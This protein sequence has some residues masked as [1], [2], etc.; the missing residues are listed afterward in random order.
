MTLVRAFGYVLLG[1]GA[2]P[3]FYLL[4]LGLIRWLPARKRNA[5]PL[6]VAVLIP[7]H[8]EEKTVVG[9]L[10]DLARQTR[11]PAIVLVI[12]HNC[13]DDTA[14]VARAAGAQ[15]LV[16]DTGHEK[17]HAL[18][19]GLKWLEERSWDAVLIVDA[20]CRVRPEC[21][22]RLRGTPN[23]VAQGCIVLDPQAGGGLMLSFFYRL[24]ETILHRGRERMGMFE[25]LRGTGLLLGR[26]ALARCPWGA[27]GLTEDRAQTYAFLSAGIP[28]RFDE[29]LVVVAS[30]P[31]RSE[32]IWNQRRRWISTGLPA[33]VFGASRA[34]ARA[35]A[36][37]G[38]KAWELPL[39][40]W[41]DARSQWLLLLMLGTLLLAVS[42]GGYIW[43]LALLGGSAVIAFMLGLAWY[44]SLFFR[45]LLE[46]PRSATL[47][48][49]AALFGLVGR[50][51]TAWKRGR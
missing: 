50:R 32:D 15:V 48:C 37:L 6:Q 27:G 17:S 5:P 29:E 47:V 41:T 30:P 22:E 46:V 31:E 36:H 14:R 23:D 9:L 19:A 38:W 35:S 45:A 11:A 4:V 3:I 51:P 20:D 18:E 12:A 1:V 42:G 28:T 34:A 33:Q 24:D 26:D 16:L 21:I 25:L 44:R 7:A 43:G 40:V 39:A 49:G 2:V 10:D 8:N 13:S